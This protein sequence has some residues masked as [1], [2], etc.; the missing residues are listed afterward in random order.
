[1]K[2]NFNKVIGC[3]VTILMTAPIFAQ[4]IIV[5]TDA[6]KIE[7]Q[8]LEVSKFEI[9]YKEYDNL[10]G[11]TF[12]ISTNEISSVIYQNGK[13][14]LYNQADQTSSNSEQ[15][16]LSNTSAPS[17]NSQQ[18]NTATIF[19]L[20]GQIITGELIEMNSR[21]VACIDN[22]T[23]KTI[24]A[25]Q[26][27]SVALSNGQVKEYNGISETHIK[28]APVLSYVSRS[29]NTYYYEGKKMRGASYER[30]LEENCSEAYDLYHKGDVTAAAG[31]TLLACGLGFDIGAT[32]GAL[33]LSSA[34]VGSSPAITAFSVIGA[35]CEIACIPTLCV[36]Y[37]Q[38]HKSADVFN[39]TCANKTPQAYWSI[40]ASPNGLG[41]AYNF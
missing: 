35:C 36:G 13:V 41:I 3:L 5:T 34:K 33:I 11:P 39:T 20:S 6:K 14:V 40:N 19:L 1:M 10:D 37:A 27:Q 26:I 29:G 24:P 18:E 9:K 4:D 7:A 38:K 31:W 12:I 28:K 22:G 25:S 16:T 21:Y 32:I 8:I 23:Q 30:F 2:H 17:K 15:T